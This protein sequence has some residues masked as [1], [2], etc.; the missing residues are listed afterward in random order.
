MLHQFDVG[1]VL[2]CWNQ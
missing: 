2:S 1:C